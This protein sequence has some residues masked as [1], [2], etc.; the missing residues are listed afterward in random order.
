MTSAHASVRA[1]SIVVAGVVGACVWILPFSA[2][3]AAPYPPIPTTV[4]ASP[5]GPG[6]PAL[7]PGGA[8][9]TPTAAVAADQGVRGFPGGVVAPGAFPVQA[10]TGAGSSPESGHPGL[11]AVVAATSV[12]LTLV[13]MVAMMRSPR[14]RLRRPR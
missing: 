14:V 8:A 10:P 11:L 3:D 9:L 7:S 12:A 2:A 6:I 1:A 13:V 5:T 4:N